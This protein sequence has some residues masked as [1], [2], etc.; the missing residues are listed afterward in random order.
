MADQGSDEAVRDALVVLNARD[1]DVCK[2]S[3]QELP[4]QK[5]WL[6]G[7]TEAEIANDV[8]A[9]VLREQ[10]FDRVYVVAD[11]VIVRPY[12][13]EAVRSLL[14]DGHPVATGY[15]Q[16]SHTDWE[17]NITSGPLN[18]RAPVEGAYD[19]VRYADVVSSPDPTIP[20]WFAGM[21][22]TGMSGEMWRR[23]PFGCYQDAGS[24]NGYA[25]DFHLSLRLQDAGV[26]IVC[27]REGFAYHWRH[28][29]R[30]TNHPADATPLDGVEQGVTLT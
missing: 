2:R 11:D 15:S 10:E 14:D 25:S 16:R 8:F 24:P 13:L 26:P 3:L 28:E 12:A 27:A 17:V 18:G 29:W 20:T 5:V 23:F 6:T 9:S 19:F 21:S 22:V 1:I 30:H 4:I 7:Y